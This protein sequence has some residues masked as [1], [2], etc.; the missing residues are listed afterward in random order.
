MFAKTLSIIFENSWLSGEVPS[1]W[2]N[3]NITPIF[4]K[5]RKEDQGNYRPVNLT[6]VSEKIMV[7][8]FLE[9]MLRHMQD[10]KLVQD[11]QNGFTKV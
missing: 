4:N 2:K 9:E 5:R 6:S 10:E 8:I 7:Q 11:S 1:D 3:V